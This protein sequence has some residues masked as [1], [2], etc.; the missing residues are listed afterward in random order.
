MSIGIA[1]PTPSAVP[2]VLWICALI[3]ITRPA[4]SKSG[5]ARVPSVDRRVDLDRVRDAEPGR[6][7]V[8]RTARR[9]HHPDGERRLLAERAADRCHGR[10]D[11]DTGRVPER[12]RRESV[13]GR[14][15]ADDADV[16]EEIPADDPRGDPL[17]VRELDVDRPRAAHVPS[18]LR[19]VRDHVGIRENRP[20]A[21]DDEPGA[22]RFAVGAEVR[23]DRHDAVCARGVERARIER[24]AARPR[25]QSRGGRRHVRRRQHGRGRAVA[26]IRGAHDE[27]RG[28]RRRL[29]RRR[30]RR[31]LRRA[32]ASRPP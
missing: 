28:T 20:R 26:E 14:G 24:A 32:G 13:V 17:A 8:D 3:P 21:V 22:L 2:L 25:R 9:G 1:N 7:R 16:A 11:D 15:H 12:D 6:E 27:E 4:A 31:P 10:P 23:V 30:R 19:H 18:R 5:P 29:R